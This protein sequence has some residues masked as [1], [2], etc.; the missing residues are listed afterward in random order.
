M[1][2]VGVG[3]MLA[4]SSTL[5]LLKGFFAAILP[6]EGF[7]CA[8]TLVGNGCNHRFFETT[9]ELATF[10]LHQDAA[11]KTIYH[12]CASFKTA[13]NRKQENAL[14]ARSLWL[15]VDA[16][17]GKPYPDAF[18]AAEAVANFCRSTGLPPPTY[19]GSGNGVHAY[20]PLAEALDPETWRAR[21]QRL[22]NACE[23]HGLHADPSRAADI[24]S[25]LRSPGTYNR[26]NATP[27]LVQVG[28]LAGPYRPD[29]FLSRLPP[30]PL[31][32]TP[33]EFGMSG[34]ARLPRN[35]TRPIK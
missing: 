17:D 25:I 35:T 34:P 20:W 28:P 24:A 26:K 19:V 1:C 7:K 15:D 6:T 2:S 10:V 23:A 30:G 31:R 27:R 12:A 22:K 18:A 13:E 16:G 33:L 29:E 21:A 8:A 32:G 9:D 14:C 4:R 3:K 5:E 11:G